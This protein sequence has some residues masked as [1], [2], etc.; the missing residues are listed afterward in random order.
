[1][2]VIHAVSDPRQAT[3]ER[4]QKMAGTSSLETL[5]KDA[6]SVQQVVSDVCF[7]QRTLLT[8]VHDIMRFM[9]LVLPQFAF[10]RTEQMLTS[11]L[12]CATQLFKFVDLDAPSSLVLWSQ[13]IGESNVLHVNQHWRQELPLQVVKLFNEDKCVR[14]LDGFG[15]G[16]VRSEKQLRHSEKDNLLRK[17]SSANPFVLQI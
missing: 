2:Y 16:A 11:P 1:M 13:D 12:E 14:V 5:M 6:K 3:F 17:P 10:V 9:R 4:L 8:L 7:A 15:F